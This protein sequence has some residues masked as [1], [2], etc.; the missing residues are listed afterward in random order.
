VHV[1]RARAA[2]DLA[3]CRAWVSSA[4]RNGQNENS[5]IFSAEGLLAAKAWERRL[6]EEHSDEGDYTVEDNWNVHCLQV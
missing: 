4:F 1:G 3:C 2:K 5:A 6:A